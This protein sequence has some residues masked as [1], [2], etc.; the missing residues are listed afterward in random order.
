MVKKVMPTRNP[1]EAAPTGGHV[2]E[3]LHPTVDERKKQYSFYIDER[4]YREFMAVCK[5]NGLSGSRAI[6]AMMQD[7]VDKYR[8]K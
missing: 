3:L 4:V 1:Q 8:K 6:N 5:D 2:E 7:F